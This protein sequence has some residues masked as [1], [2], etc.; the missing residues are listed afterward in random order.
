MNERNLETD[1]A[2]P[3][4]KWQQLLSA[5]LVVVLILLV[6]FFSQQTEGFLSAA[7][8][9]N[10]ARDISLIGI[11]GTG[12]TLLV[13]TGHIDLSVG[14]ILGVSGMVYGHMMVSESMSIGPALIVAL[15]AGTLLGVVNGLSVTLLGINPIIATLAT[16]QAYRGVSFLISDGIPIY[17]FPSGIRR[18]GSGELLG[19]PYAVWVAA[20]VFCAGW[21]VLN[22]LPLGRHIYAIGG[23]PEAARMSGLNLRSTTVAL[24]ALTGLLAAVAG[25]LVASRLESSAPNSGTGFEISVIT[26]VFVGGVSYQGGAG[27]LGGVFLGVL[28]L[29]VLQNGMTLMSVQPFV[30]QVVFGTF[31]LIAVALDQGLNKLST[32]VRFRL[33]D[34]SEAPAS[35]PPIADPST[36]AATAEEAR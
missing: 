36:Y 13:I 3:E 20:V 7:N 28:T 11:V 29:G 9:R 35:R 14:S 22:R 1:D 26:A 25:V 8:A 19:L 18:L 33:R 27:R 5:G 6:I 10:I 24:Y 17:G 16:W 15:I 34:P 32:R 23:N 2:N 12:M 21:I 30:Q 4:R 31:L